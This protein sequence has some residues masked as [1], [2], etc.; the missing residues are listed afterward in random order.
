MPT[1]S[2]ILGR[3]KLDHPD[4][5]HDGGAA[6]ETKIKTL[7]T[8]LADAMPSRFF[9]AVSLADGAS[10]DFDHNFQAAFSELGAR[11]Y[12]WDNGTGELSRVDPLTGWT[13]AATA[14]FLTKKVTVTNNT[15]SAKTFALWL[16]QWPLIEKLDD[17]ADVDLVSAAPEDGQAMVYNAALAKWVPGASGDSS[18]KIQGVTDPNAT[19]KGGFMLLPDGR[20]VATYDGAGSLSTDFG[21]DLVVNLSTILGS[22]PAN[23]TAYYLALDLLTL[24]AAVTQTDT[25]R[26]V[27]PITEANFVLTTTTP[28][29]A[30]RNRLIFRSVIRSADSGTVWS[31]TGSKFATLAFLKG[32][33]AQAAQ[34]PIVHTTSQ[35]VGAVGSTS[36]I[37]QGH[38]LGEKSFPVA[39]R[40]TANLSFWNLANALTDAY[41]GARSFTAPNGNSGTV[42]IFG[43]SNGAIGL[44]SASSQYLNNAAAMLNPGN[45]NFSMGGWFYSSDWIPASGQWLFSQGNDG[46]DRSFALFLDSNGTMSVRAAISAGSFAMTAVVAHGIPDATPGWHHIAL[47]YTAAGNFFS[48]FLNG[49]SIWQ[50]SLGGNLRSSTTA[51]LQ[52]GA[53]NATVFFNGSVD[54]FFA[55]VG[56][57]LTDVDIAKLASTKITHNKA[58]AASRQ[59]WYGRHY[60]GGVSPVSDF[61][62]FV[63]DMADA[64]MAFVDLSGCDPTDKVDLMLLDTGAAGAISVPVQTPEFYLTANIGAGGLETNL[65][66]AP[67]SLQGW[68]LDSSNRWQPLDLVGLVYVDAADGLKLKGDISSLSP[69]VSNPVRIV[70]STTASAQ[71]VGAAGAGQSGLLNYYEEATHTSDFTMDNSG[72]KSGSKS[73]SIVRIGKVVTLTLPSTFATSNGSDTVLVADVALPAQFRPYTTQYMQMMNMWNA[74]GNMTTP[75]RLAILSNGTIQIARD[76]ANTAWSAGANCGSYG[77]VSVSFIVA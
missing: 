61:S 65:A 20:E 39:A 75:G 22:A 77:A 47:R 56:V 41:G 15:G 69:S 6:L 17:L 59:L 58:M 43:E 8:L 52:I 35:V 64:N 74:G 11:L 28:E 16:F 7:Y 70:V 37:R 73:L 46:A 10:I 49:K 1:T 40:N 32:E 25:G 50:E 44:A 23:A 76:G 13:I 3:M 66:E 2:T 53:C 18:F 45:Q 62:G 30:N 29:A 48:L 27:Y 57:A 38:I 34:N 55:V 9:T 51:V 68:Q 5:G 24:G 60:A 4:L 67:R 63:L 72:N 12:L 21:K 42:G 33:V 71:A 54:E 31:G 19:I 26:V 14:G 36:Q